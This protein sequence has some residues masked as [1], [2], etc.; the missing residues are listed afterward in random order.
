ME[1]TKHLQ[2]ICRSTVICVSLCSSASF[3][4]ETVNTPVV[5][6]AHS[7]EME[8]ILLISFLFDI[9]VSV[10]AYVIALSLTNLENFNQIILSSEI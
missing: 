5:R 9:F 2:Q 3:F 10:L 1:Y 4:P 7:C 8:L 6:L